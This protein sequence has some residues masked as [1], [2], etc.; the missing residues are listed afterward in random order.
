M[1]SRIMN[2]LRMYRLMLQ[3]RGRVRNWQEAWRAIRTHTLGVTLQL[4]N[5]L[6]IR[7]ECRDDVAWIFNEIFVERCYTPAWFYHPEPGHTVLDV[8]ANIGLFSLYLDSVAHGIRVL[9][10]EP[11]PETFNVLT[12]NLA[13]NHLEGTITARRLAVSRGPGEV[14]F[15]GLRGLDSGHDPATTTGLGE[16][17]DCIG[18]SEALEL[19]EGRPIDL[20]K[21]DTEGAEVE[22]ISSAPLAIWSR[23]ARVVVEYHDLGKRDEVVRSLESSGYQCRVEPSR[24]FEGFLGLI[25]ARR[26][27]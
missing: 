7:G 17:V 19:A 21:V 6:I 5:G 14:R 27:A 3:F 11:H 23:I 4:R 26:P 20:L 22:I 9:A 16:A 12:T 18:L 24:G 13:E 1:L 2:R 8:G 10:F 25:Y 15:S